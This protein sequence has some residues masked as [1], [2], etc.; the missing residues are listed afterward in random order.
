MSLIDL[1]RS[2]AKILEISQHLDSLSHEE[3]LREVR[4]LSGADQNRLFQAAASS[5][6]LDFAFFVPDGTPP[7]T[8]V[9]H[10]GKNSQ[11][12]FRNFEKRWCKP[13][14][15][16][17]VCYGYNET[18]VRPLIGPGYFVARETDDG[19]RDPRGAIVVDYF[20]TPPE[21]G[22]APGWPPV[23]P[24]SSGLQRFVYHQTRDYMRRVSAHVSIG[25]AHRLEKRVMGWFI[26]CRED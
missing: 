3:R 26:L 24:N 21:D 19:G 2:E 23:K 8:Q 10:H 12:A 20:M 1:V 7:L 5:P 6:P 18:V 22:K 13:A 25:E 16:D 17:D 9:I 15:R 14:D 11:P 4:S